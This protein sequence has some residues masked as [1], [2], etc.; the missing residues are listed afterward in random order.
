MLT[1]VT[2]VHQL[3]LK[4]IGENPIQLRNCTK[5]RQIIRPEINLQL[6]LSLCQFLKTN[7]AT[8]SADYRFQNI[9]S[10]LKTPLKSKLTCIGVKKI[11]WPFADT[12]LR[13]LTTLFHTSEGSRSDWWTPNV[14]NLKETLTVYIKKKRFLG[15]ALT[16]TSLY[17]PTGSII[18]RPIGP[19]KS[20]GGESLLR[21]VP[22]KHN[23]SNKNLANLIRIH[24]SNLLRLSE[25]KKHQRLRQVRHLKGYQRLSP[26]VWCCPKTTRFLKKTVIRD[27]VH[28]D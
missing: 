11:V 12:N 2:R 4:R 24:Q 15:S 17:L 28:L 7:S 1:I 8:V 19:G 13:S 5:R 21:N 23:K 18:I 27:K 10:C 14:K 16:P 26:R 25:A 3:P 20:I 22:K 9:G 6:S